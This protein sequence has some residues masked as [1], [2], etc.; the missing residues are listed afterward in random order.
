VFGGLLKQFN[1]LMNGC[2]G[3]YPTRHACV[4]SSRAELVEP[5]RTEYPA[6]PAPGGVFGWP[7]TPVWH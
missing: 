1:S 7:F 2:N 6:R 3:K 4:E 5:A